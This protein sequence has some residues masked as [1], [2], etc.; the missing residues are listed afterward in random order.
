MPNNHFEGIAVDV[1][2]ERIDGFEP[3]SR[4]VVVRRLTQFRI[5]LGKKRPPIYMGAARKVFG[6]FG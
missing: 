1:V 4:G 3:R 2:G 5:G 6:Q